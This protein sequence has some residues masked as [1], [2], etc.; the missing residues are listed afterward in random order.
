[1][2][3]VIDNKLVKWIFAVQV[4]SFFFTEVSDKRRYKDPERRGGWGTQV[5]REGM[6][7]VYRCR[8]KGWRGTQVWRE[9]VEGYTGVE[10]RD[11]GGVQV[12]R[13]GTE[14]VHRC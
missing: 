10:G 6:E 14:G 3:S 12:W 4:C 13:E 2:V 11:G 7:G 5:L 1:M 8:G 9:G